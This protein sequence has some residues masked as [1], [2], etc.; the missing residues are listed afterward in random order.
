MHTHVTLKSTYSIY[1]TFFLLSF[2]YL[3][4]TL[5]VLTCWPWRL[6]SDLGCD[7]M[8][9]KQTIGSN[10]SDA[11]TASNVASKVVRYTD[12]LV[13]VYKPTR[14]HIPEDRNVIHLYIY[15]FLVALLIFIY[16]FI[17]YLFPFFFPP[18]FLSLFLP[19]NKEWGKQINIHTFVCILT[20]CPSKCRIT[21]WLQP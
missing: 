4:L 16:L 20:K 21:F 1:V 10:V 19:T 11:P 18:F 14:Y 9:Y 6:L 15:L 3:L 2:I 7:A 17:C 12:T 5:E 13:L 8:Y